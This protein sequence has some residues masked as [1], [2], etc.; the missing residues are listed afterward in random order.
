MIMC[1]NLSYLTHFGGQGRNPRNISLHFWKNLRHYN[2]V[3]R[4]SD[5]QHSPNGPKRRIHFPKCGLQ[6][7]CIQNWAF[8]KEFKE[9]RPELEENEKIC[10]MTVVYYALQILHVLLI[11]DTYIFFGEIYST[12]FLETRK[13][14]KDL[15]PVLHIS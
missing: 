2:F 14:L 12:Q 4:L 8:N 7:N 5:L 1:L 6:T 15:K 13:W 9:L 11:T 10:A 3:L